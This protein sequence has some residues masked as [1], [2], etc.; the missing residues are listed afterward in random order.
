MQGITKNEW[1][2]IVRLLAKNPLP[3][4]EPLIG[5]FDN[6]L[7]RSYAGRALYASGDIENALM[8]LATV[9]DVEPNLNDK[10]QEGFSEC[11][12][13]ILC[14]MDLAEIIWSLAKNAE[15]AVRYIDDAI[16]LC[17][18]FT[19]EFLIA[20]EAKCEVRRWEILLANGQADAEEKLAQAKL[21]LKPKKEQEK[22]SIYEVRRRNYKNPG[23][24]LPEI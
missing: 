2:E 12:H 10:P 22:L 7:C 14:L 18:K 5:D 20:D 8:V 24:K 9:I 23:I 4:P 15:A 19:G 21:K 17:Q 6:W 13:K 1:G 16:N 11:E 3:V